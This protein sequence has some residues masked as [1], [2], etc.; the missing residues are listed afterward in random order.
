MYAIIDS[1]IIFLYVA[2]AGFYI[3][4]QGEKVR[5]HAI[6]KAAPILLLAITLLFPASFLDQTQWY[7]LVALVLSAAGDIFLAL[8]DDGNYFVPGLGSFLIAHIFYTIAFVQ[9]AAFQPISLLPI[10]IIILL[11]IGVTWRIWDGLDELK[12]P[13]VFYILVSMVMGFS[14]AIHAPISWTLI[15]GTIIFMVSDSI[16]ALDKFWTTIQR[17]DILVMG[18]YYA[19]QLLIFLGIVLQA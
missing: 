7:I 19:A 9:S 6:I 5:G 14:A 17:G 8:D 11:G 1:M 3:Y 4:L 12:L 10:S 18:T 15:A 16:I 13:V 2:L